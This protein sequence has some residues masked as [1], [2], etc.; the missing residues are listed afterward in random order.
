[1]CRFLL[2]LAIRLV[3]MLRF[4]GGFVMRR[5]GRGNGLWLVVV[6]LVGGG[7]VC[8]LT[9]MCR[10]LWRGLLYYM[11]LVRLYLFVSRILLRIMSFRLTL[12]G[13]LWLLLLVFMIRVRRYRRLDFGRSISPLM[14]TGPLLGGRF[15]LLIRGLISWDL[16]YVKS[17]RL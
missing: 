12:L 1:M 8:R 2:L 11:L 7:L 14:I 15:L 3:R 16:G 9:W 17:V 5:V 10:R 6:R 4:S 13:T